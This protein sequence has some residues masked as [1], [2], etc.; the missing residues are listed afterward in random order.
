[1]FDAQTMA[2][3]L[4]P[5]FGPAAFYLFVT[6]F[7]FASFSSLVVNPFIGA[8]LL[9]DGF[10]RDPSI[11][12]RPVRMW[13]IA[14]LGV[15]LCVVLLFKGSPIELLR[16]AQALAVVAFPVLGFLLWTIARDKRVMGDAANSTLMDLI[17]G[18]GYLTIIGIVLN[19]IRQI[20]GL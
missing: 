12:S 20:V 2:L 14:I 10:G 1:V 16:I 18:L 15:G 13:A 19:Y 17:A 9:T 4:E 3:Q 5:F 7:F 8:T 6:G 11:D